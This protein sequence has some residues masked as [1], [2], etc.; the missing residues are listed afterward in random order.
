MKILP[1]PKEVELKFLADECCDTGIV[2]SLRADGHD[3]LYILEEKT[4]VSDDEVLLEAYNEGRILLTEDKDFGELV[5]RLKKSSKGII[6]IRINVKERHMKWPCLKKL[7]EN[8]SDRLSGHFVVI[9]TKKF[10]F[11][12]LLFSL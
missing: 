1:L 2:T 10:R 11:R 7:I 12:P 8:Y 6:L 9:N 5:Y 3:V 4:G